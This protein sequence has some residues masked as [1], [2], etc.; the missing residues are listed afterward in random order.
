MTEPIYV[1]CLIRTSAFEEE[2]LFYIDQV[3]G[4]RYV[5]F[6]PAHYCFTRERKPFERGEPKNEAPGL[7]SARLVENGGDTAWV[8]LP[9]GETILVRANTVS[10][11]A[12]SERAHVSVG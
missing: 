10:K 5:G 4:A 6:A 11:R 8:Y 1:E 3:E 2:R 9:S 12:V 7:V